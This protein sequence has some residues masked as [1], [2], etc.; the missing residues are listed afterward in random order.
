MDR[1]CALLCLLLYW[2]CTTATAPQPADQRSDQQALLCILAPHPLRRF[3]QDLCP[4]NSRC[5][6]NI[7]LSAQST[8]SCLLRCNIPPTY[9][10]TTLVTDRLPAHSSSFFAL[11]CA[12][13]YL[14]DPHQLDGDCILSPPPLLIACLTH[15]CA[16]SF[17]ALNHAG[18]Y[19]L[20]VDIKI[21]DI[22]EKNPRTSVI[23]S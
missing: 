14:V 15:S 19:P 7:S 11:I 20:L 8:L 17:F 10:P 1:V 2:V 23:E 6:C 3:V 18:I 22:R 9:R 5:T 21:Y 12:G 13:T 4:F 16:S